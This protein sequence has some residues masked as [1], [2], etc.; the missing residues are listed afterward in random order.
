MNKKILDAWVDNLPK[1]IE[2]LGYLINH[3]LIK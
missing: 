2:P 1:V 3:Y